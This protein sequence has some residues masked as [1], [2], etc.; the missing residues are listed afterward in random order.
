MASVGIDPTGLIPESTRRR[1]FDSLVDFLAS[2]TEKAGG[3][4]AAQA[5]RKLGSDA[6]FQAEVDAALERA[7][8]RF[9][10]GYTEIDRE[11]LVALVLQPTR[12]L[13]DP[14]VR[15]AVTEMVRRPGTYLDP[16]REVI[17]RSFANL[18]P[19][20]DAP[21][22]NRAVAFF[23][24]KLAQEVM[25]IRQLAPV[26]GVQLQR[27]SLEQGREMVAA[28]RDLQADQRRAM[29][30]LLEIL[31]D[32]PERPALPGPPMVLHNLPQPDYVRFV[33]REEEL[34]SVHALLSPSERAW[35][36]TIDGIGGIGK[37][38]LALEVAHRYR[39]EHD[40]LP[41]EERFRA[42]IWSSAKASVLT[43]SGIAPRQ[44]ITRTL[45]DIYATI[46]VTLERED[47]NRARPEDRDRVVAKALT[48]QRT[49]LIVD[50][51]ETVDDERVNAF[52]RELPAP[53]KAIVTTRHRI[54]VAYPVRLTGMSEEDGLALIAQERE[55]K[56]AP[57][58]PADAKKLFD[59][60][61]GVPLAMVW[62]VAQ[63]GSGY[64]VDTL[65]RRLA[66]PTSDIALY[67]FEAALKRIKGKPAHKL[68]MALALFVP[69]ASREALG[70]VA[71]LPVLD[72]DD[73]LVELERLSLVNRHAGRFNFLPL[74]KVFAA[75][76]LTSHRDFREEASSRWIEYLKGLCDSGES[77]YFWRYRT[78]RFIEEGDNLIEAIRWSYEY[79]TN[80][81]VFSLTLAAYEY[82]EVVGQ[83]NEVLELCGKALALA[84]SS[85]NARAIARLSQVMGWILGSRGEYAEAEAHFS[86]A[87]SNYEQE[88]ERA[89]QSIAL[90]LLA[91]NYRQQEAFAEARELC[92]R[93]WEIAQDLGA[94]DLKALIQTEYGKLARD[95]EDWELAWHH[96]TGVKQWFEERKEETPRDESLARG[97]WGQLALVAYHLGRP[98][99]ARDLCL[100][101][102][103]FFETHGAKG[104][105]ATLKYRL[106]L[107]EQALGEHEAALEHVREAMD[108]FDRLGMKPDYEEAEELIQRLEQDRGE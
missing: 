73:G 28:L 4:R 55:K 75:N 48:G 40:Q 68:L 10:R 104:Y 54:D 69:D 61:G 60:T 12:F 14:S 42:I 106:A 66:Q 59:R 6:E 107:A 91:R 46:A 65:L 17:E 93:A 86:R 16:E 37:S 50:N 96:F 31:S 44:Q 92:D 8:L 26:Y 13:D 79:G 7:V 25:Y 99:E 87:L 71:D 72:R 58:T 27:L 52:L 84:E 103:E 67:C 39:R 41:P 20:F 30:A 90:H 56:N 35:V 62:S 74:T 108:W 51:L 85:Q 88:E 23:L 98:K 47:I 70:Y 36:V 76:E 105:V 97:N 38:A 19:G 94:G 24:S 1:L 77:E 101:S 21:R 57:L 18:L 53:T 78:Y 83:W 63:I 15:D 102:L 5:L 49:L 29:M 81:D 9:I 82:L 45:E 80:E 43:A 2:Q 32:Y 22:V 3:R 89:G 100:K 33:G 11:V 95:M 34:A 64:N